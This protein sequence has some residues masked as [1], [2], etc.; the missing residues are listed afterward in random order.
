[1][2]FLNRALPKNENLYSNFQNNTDQRYELWKRSILFFILFGSMNYTTCNTLSFLK[3]NFVPILLLTP[4]TFIAIFFMINH[5][6]M[7]SRQNNMRSP[8]E[9][10]QEEKYKQ[11]ILWYKSQVD[12]LLTPERQEFLLTTHGRIF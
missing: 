6:I 7:F 2:R 11:H 9:Q 1:M 10:E 3:K 8:E 5:R 12:E 4:C